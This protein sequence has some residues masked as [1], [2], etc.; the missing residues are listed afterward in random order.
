MLNSP[1]V[2]HLQTPMSMLRTMSPAT[3]VG[4][5][6]E[7]L[8]R[9]LYE[10]AA[11]EIQLADLLPL[12]PDQDAPFIQTHIT[13]KPE[14]REK[15]SGPREDQ[16][17]VRGQLFNQ[18]EVTKRF[19]M[20]VG[21]RLLIISETGTGKA[22]AVEGFTEAIHEQYI[23][24]VEGL[25][26]TNIKRA[27]LVAPGPLQLEDMRRQLVC[28]CSR[29]GKYDQT[30]AVLNANHEE[31][32]SAQVTKGVS[33]FYELLTIKKL[34]KLIK[35]CRTNE[36]IIEQFSDIALWIDEFHISTIDPFPFFTLDQPPVYKKKEGKESISKLEAY[37]LVWKM[38][39][40][41]QR[42]TVVFSTATP[43][44]NKV[45]E[46]VSVFNMLLPID[47]Q[48]PRNY[49]FV[50]APVE[51][52]EKLL[53]G[54]I[55]FIRAMD[56]GIEIVRH[57][58]RQNYMHVV[59]GK[60]Y[61]S[62]L[63]LQMLPM[64][65]HQSK[66][67]LQA[68]LQRQPEFVDVLK[69][70]AE[71][72]GMGSGTTV[73][74]GGHGPFP[75]RNERE[76]SM[77]V[78]PDGSYG[79][80]S[81][82]SEQVQMMGMGGQ[83]ITNTVQVARGFQKYI[84]YNSDTKW[85]DIID[86][87][88][89][90]NIRTLE[91]QTVLSAKMA[92]ASKIIKEC[93]RQE[94][95]CFIYFSE[96][97]L[98]SGAVAFSK[99]LENMDISDIAPGR[100][101]V[102]FNANT[103]VFSSNT[104]KNVKPFCADDPSTRSIKPEFEV[105][106]P[107]FSIITSN[108]SP[109]ERSIILEAN[110][111]KENMYGRINTAVISSEIGRVGI[112]IDN[113]TVVVFDASDWDPSDNY[114]AESR[115]IRA[116]SHKNLLEDRREKMGMYNVPPI[117]V[118][119]YNLAAYTHYNEEVVSVD[120]EI[121]LAA[122]HK[123]IYNR[124]VMR[125]LKEIA[126]DCHLNHERNVRQEDVDGSAACDY[127][128]CNYPCF[129]PFPSYTDYSSYDVLYT[130]PL[131]SL[132]RTQALAVLHK[133]HS[134]SFMDIYNEI[135]ENLRKE[136]PASLEGG[137]PRHK[138]LAI[139]LTRII[140]AREPIIDRYGIPSFLR[141]NSGLFYL[142]RHY[143]SNE[144]T[145]GNGY[146]AFNILSTD[147]LDLLNIN[148]PSSQEISKVWGEIE[149]IVRGMYT[150]TP[151]QQRAK[152]R[153]LSTYLYKVNLETNV[154]LLEEALFHKAVGDETEAHK[155]ISDARRTLWFAI[156][157][158][159]NGI[160]RLIGDIETNG[161]KVLARAEQPRD[162]EQVRE[163]INATRNVDTEIV[164]FHGLYIAGKVRRGSADKAAMSK[165]SGRIRLLKLSECQARRVV[166]D[167]NGSSSSSAGGSGGSGSQPV[168]KYNTEFIEGCWRDTT[169]IERIEYQAY[170]MVGTKDVE[171]TM[172]VQSDIYG[173]LKTNNL[174]VP[175]LWIVDKYKERHNISS[176]QAK[177]GKGL[178]TGHLCTNWNK[179]DIADIMYRIGIPLLQPQY[180]PPPGANEAEK[181]MYINA[182]SQVN[183]NQMIYSPQQLAAM[184][185][186]LLY[187]YYIRI[188]YVTFL[189]L[190]AWKNVV[191][192]EADLWQWPVDRLFYVYHMS[193]GRGG[194]SSRETT[195]SQIM[196][197]LKNDGL[198]I[199]RI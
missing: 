5:R 153:E 47:K 113:V 146:Y 16:P 60:E 165:F 191:Y 119:I 66:S 139:A 160:R 42:S 179:Q 118:H 18:Q 44:V 181:N 122:E 83:I 163:Y 59:D 52:L 185:T 177:G 48:L 154:M 196:E 13:A 168:P 51:E 199:E 77:L 54:K 89:T 133:R 178:S 3:P 90:D 14:F 124:G 85:Y 184:P 56:T 32:Q 106:T 166:N 117:K 8:N 53:R 84:R 141:E 93:Y 131:I 171:Q 173:Y 143:P 71:E 176:K 73:S 101:F 107:R 92:F 109:R 105:R 164:Y 26:S 80:A 75:Y 72:V 145:Q 64:S 167:A 11:D 69:V 126:F 123:D 144:D 63:I 68:W 81:M 125:K 95:V 172:S 65:S 17:K 9:A 135:I 194:S 130:E 129:D 120:R 152:E 21:D 79:G 35:R 103:S 15:S 40:L 183:I 147:E 136:Q 121:Y 94:K 112:N 38:V 115:V 182:L 100:S 67:Y 155:A 22:C 27:Y 58:D 187:Q 104:G 148:R 116:T 190:T 43:I 39:H 86:P 114:Q 46:L 162:V 24:I 23:N 25:R 195:C 161:N 180:F 31:T 96:F 29:A 110:N 99:M 134:L 57:G 50:H 142:Q 127:Q 138:F 28:R 62:Q 108:V 158:P 33:K 111:S 137:N 159:L 19:L 20:D 132:L 128:K 45:S 10:R 149:N 175:K 49:D 102:R 37:Y 97:V 186:E 1:N 197:K 61:P 98:G 189:R 174:G 140:D 188:Q 82:H 198:L 70:A 91:R 34:A 87:V 151:D 74:K 192:S 36:E 169:Q 78:F 12:H 76:A 41:I 4:R 30:E 55:S 156:N 193:Q 6:V 88:F 2:A 170:G 150:S 7:V 157:E